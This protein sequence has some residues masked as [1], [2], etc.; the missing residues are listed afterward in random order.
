MKRIIT[1]TPQMKADRGFRVRKGRWNPASGAVSLEEAVAEPV[2]G[3]AD[4]EGR[5]IR[6]GVKTIPAVSGQK[7]KVK[8][9]AYCRVSTLMES[10]ESSMEGQY[11]HYDQL[12]RSNPEWD[13]A[14]IYLEMGVTGTKAEIRLELQRM[15]EDCKQGRID[16]ILTKSISRFSR[17]TSEC[18]SMVR[19]LTALG[20]TIFFEKEQIRTGSMES[21]FMLSIL[22]CFAE[23]ESRSISNN[24]KWGLRKRFEAGTYQQAISPYGYRRTKDGF[25][26][27]REEAVVVRAIYDRILG[28]QGMFSIAEELNRVKIPTRYGGPWHPATIRHMVYNLFYV[29]D[30]L[31]QK[32]FVDET[33]RQRRNRG[34][35]DQ[36]Y[37]R[38]HHPGIIDRKV[39][40]CALRAIRQRGRECGTYTE[41][42]NPEQAAKRQNRYGF[43]GKLICGKCGAVL[44]RQ[45]N[46]YY[47]VYACPVHQG[48]NGV[49]PAGP[50]ME[51]T[52]KNAFLT[53]LNKLTYSQ[54]LGPSER[55]LDSYIR[56]TCGLERKKAKKWKTF[57]SQ[58]EIGS[59]TEDFPEEIFGKWIEKA[60]IHTGDKVTF[61][62]DCGLQP[63]CRE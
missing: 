36:F 38:A 56:N 17:N 20:V 18:L 63:S 4:V 11:R 22:A 54:S 7:E 42:E 52:I 34:E 24:M 3:L 9:A 46:R 50:E 62:F 57:I 21:E 6:K 12:M 41:N 43:S 19:E 30:V 58:R 15:M 45:K 51:D 10:Q 16:L 2:G 33:F 61:Y 39:Y 59:K 40:D 13:F 48:K 28:G 14:G 49:C 44:H 1:L 55:I 29:G 25:T 5:P 27:A 31:Y 8:V 26:I 47:A 60:V 37:E 23:E 32:T 35:L 53:C